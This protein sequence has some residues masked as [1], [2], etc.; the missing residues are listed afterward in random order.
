MSC[1]RCSNVVGQILILSTLSLSQGI[2]ISGARIMSDIISAP[3][4][5][6]SPVDS[7]SFM[8]YP[9]FLFAELDAVPDLQRICRRLPRRVVA[10]QMGAPVNLAETKEFI[11]SGAARSRTACS[12]LGGRLNVA[13]APGGDIGDAGRPRYEVG[14]VPPQT[15]GR[16]ATRKLRGKSKLT[17]HQKHDVMR[18]RNHGEG[19]LRRL[20]V[21]TLA[22]GRVQ[23]SKRDQ[24]ICK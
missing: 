24:R 22:A 13:S 3:P 19:L 2:S 11:W 12:A 17:N 21:A 14:Q 18:R 4:I 15:A 1:R 7:H 16:G 9:M 5:N 10:P 6:S 23:A 8:T 20:V